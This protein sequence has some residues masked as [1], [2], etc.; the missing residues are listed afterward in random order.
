MITEEQV[1]K[2][3]NFIHQNAKKAAQA[4]ADREYLDDFTKHLESRL[5]RDSGE[6]SVSGREMMA[7]ASDEYLGHLKDLRSA[8][9]K[10]EEYKNLYKAAEI[11]FDKW[12]TE[13][14]NQR[15]LGKI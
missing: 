10:D 7:R 14:S 8:I 6:S 12:R 9:E 11:I 1:D 4:K 13:Q 5:A 2:A 15:A 3:V